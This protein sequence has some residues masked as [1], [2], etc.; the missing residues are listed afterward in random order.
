MLFF[1]YIGI[2]Q[3]VTDIRLSVDIALK[4]DNDLL[5]YIPA[6]ISRA[7][8]MSG[9]L[10]PRQISPGIGLWSQKTACASM[11][12]WTIFLYSSSYLLLLNLTIWIGCHTFSYNVVAR[13]TTHVLSI[14]RADRSKL[15]DM[16]KARDAKAWQREF[17]G[18]FQLEFVPRICY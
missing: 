14:G 6:N 11:F 7:V 1:H 18:E 4:S 9:I 15:H 12:W 3:S 17:L 5:F 13:L 8:W 2:K 10:S 16:F